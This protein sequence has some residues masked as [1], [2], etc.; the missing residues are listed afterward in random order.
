MP[1]KTLRLTLPLIA[2]LITT[3]AKAQISTRLTDTVKSGTGSINL[4]KDISGAQLAQQISSSGKLFFGM[5]INENASGNE[6][7][8]SIGVA[9]QSVELT[10]TTTTGTYRFSNCATNTTAVLSQAGSSGLNTYHTLFGQIGSSQLTSGSTGFDLGAFDDVLVLNN[11][12]FTGD[13]LSATMS[14]RLLDTGSSRAANDTF[15][16]FSGGYED[17]ALLNMA[18]AYAL[19]S[20][21]IG[22]AGA[23]SGVTYSTT[24]PVITAAEVAAGTTTNSTTGGNTST[25]PNSPG[26]PT[27][28]PAAP[29]PSV[30][31]LIA[32]SVLLLVKLGMERRKECASRE[33]NVQA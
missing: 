16:D 29:A 2:L 9:L 24:T 7:S 31:A 12:A 3:A 8:N 30:W 26:S 14:L 13:V 22:V 10:V 23:P 32:L 19:E 15:F 27:A 1:M 18:D 17:L 4:L 5:D 21:N 28:P 11:V 6:N 25:T 33:A 20:A